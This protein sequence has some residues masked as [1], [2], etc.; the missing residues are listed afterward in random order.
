MSNDEISDE[1]RQARFK[2]WEALGLEQVKADLQVGGYRVV[3][4]PPQVRALAWE[5][6]RLKEEQRRASEI[7]QEDSRSFGIGQTHAFNA[8]TA[9]TTEKQTEIVTLKP[10]F[11]GVSVDVKELARRF[12]PR[13]RRFLK[14]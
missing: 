7:S 12:Y 6:V 1:A 3:G 5:W 4:G 13:V 8:T 10:G 2:R 14:N 11:M 9:K